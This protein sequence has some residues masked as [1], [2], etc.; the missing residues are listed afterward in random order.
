M[1]QIRIALTISGAVSLGA[2]EGGALAALVQ[3]VQALGRRGDSPMRIDAIGGASAGSITAVLTARCLLEGIDPVHVMAESWVRRDSLAAMR[4]RDAHAPLS[5][6]PMRR[7]AVELLDP[8]PSFG[9]RPRQDSPIVIHMALGCLRGLTFT[10]GRLEGSPIEETTFL[11]WGQFTLLPDMSVTDYTEPPD[12][13]VVDFALASAANAFGFA[14]KLLDRTKRPEDREMLARGEITNLP[15]DWSGS[16]WYTD[17]G[18]ID[19]EPLGRTFGIANDIDADGQG[20][21]I[22]VLIHPHPTQASRD[23]RWTVL[24]ERPTWLGTFLRCDKLQR[25]HSLYDDL[26][27]A[28][29]TNSRLIWTEHLRNAITPLLEAANDEWVRV[30]WPVLHTILE[31]KE[32]IDRKE[33]DAI[34]PPDA[35]E[36]DAPLPSP[37][38]NDA[39]ELFRQ[40][41]AV[42]T[43]LGGKQPA[44]IEVVSPLLLDEATGR[45]V[46]DLLAGEF[47]LHFGGFLDERLRWHDFALGYRSMQR[48][49]EG[50]EGLGVDASDAELART[51]VASRYRSE[52][53]TGWG[54]KSLGSLPWSDRLDLARLATHIGRVAAGE[55]MQRGRTS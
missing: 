37:P 27:T 23:A 50:L 26:R 7:A 13:S 49:L 48:W 55:L 31:Q 1:E 5:I 33:P 24:S 36:K 54:T 39:T 10:M 19:N 12:A 45:R 53:N 34:R 4:T 11:D 41:L 42:A 30:L 38:T 35:E 18:T 20:R 46:E 14:P 43:G 15:T 47:L 40:V 8:P 32:G 3:A 6:E 25:T 29:K 52:W 44:R 21:R 2:Y 51:E 28:E 17:G 9:G 22:H 16:L